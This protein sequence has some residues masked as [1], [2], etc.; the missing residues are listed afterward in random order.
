MLLP[1]ASLGFFIG[2]YLTQR[3]DPKS[4]YE[5]TYFCLMIISIKLLY[6]GIQGI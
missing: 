6:E 3:I 5:I 4:F 2:Y 1:F